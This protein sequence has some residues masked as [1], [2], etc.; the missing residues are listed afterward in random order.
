MSRNS[1]VRPPASPTRARGETLLRSH[2]GCGRTSRL[3]A[4]ERPARGH[5]LAHTGSPPRT[6]VE[7]SSPEAVLD[8]NRPS[9][10]G[11]I[12][13]SFG[14]GGSDQAAKFAGRCPARLWGAGFKP[15]GRR[16]GKARKEDSLNGDDRRRHGF[17]RV[18]RRGRISGDRSPREGSNRASAS[19]AGAGFRSRIERGPGIAY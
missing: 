12:A 2:Q 10:A 8:L 3:R 14:Q 13:D 18:D 17:S 4:A 16:G 6:W 15:S 1:P 5:Q 9:R 11:A 7:R 19:I